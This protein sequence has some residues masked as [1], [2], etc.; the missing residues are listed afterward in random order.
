M[1][2]IKLKEVRAKIMLR[3]IKSANL[4]EMQDLVVLKI[5]QRSSQLCL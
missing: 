3:L 1:F 4:L 5:S 2:R